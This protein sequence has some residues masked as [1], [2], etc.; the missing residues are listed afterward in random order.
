MNLKQLVYEGWVIQNKLQ[1]D[2]LV[3]I[4]TEVLNTLIGENLHKIKKIKKHVQHPNNYYSQCLNEHAW[5]PNRH[6]VCTTITL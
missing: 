6:P 5:H 1:E 2:S 4:W 3:A